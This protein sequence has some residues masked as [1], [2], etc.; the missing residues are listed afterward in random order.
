MERQETQAEMAEPEEQSEE[1][2]GQERTCYSCGAEVP[3]GRRHCPTCGARQVR[4]CFCGAR[5]P[6]TARRCPECGA[7]WSL[8]T[9]VKRKSRS[10]RVRPHA[11]AAYAAGGAVA[12][13]LLAAIIE[14]VVTG[15]A[16]QALQPG[17]GMPPAFGG[18]LRLA[19]AAV[20]SFLGRMA[21]VASSHQAG[22][23]TFLVVL[24]MG[25][26]LGAL[27]Y[28]HHVGLLNR[29][30]GASRSRRKRRGE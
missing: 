22:L 26:V 2:S 7:D 5:I 12:A 24:L 23:K 21:R 15:L 25:A 14:L 27:Y 19:A 29:T 3:V 10:R 16:A 30:Q 28:L 18:K 6:A 9:R 13:A 8:S 17:E 11:L 20:G 1:E 4:T